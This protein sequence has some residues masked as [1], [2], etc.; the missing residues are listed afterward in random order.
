M[1]KLWGTILC[2]WNG[3]HYHPAIAPPTSL[4]DAID[5][6]IFRDMSP[7]RCVVQNVKIHQ[8]L[9]PV[10]ALMGIVARIC[11]YPWW[12]IIRELFFH[13]HVAY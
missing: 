7:W 9:A 8:K 5:S 6:L 1:M 12:W 11:Q 10:I 2:R 13:D 3:N 4:D